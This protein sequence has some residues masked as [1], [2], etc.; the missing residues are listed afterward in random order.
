MKSWPVIK[1]TNW[2]ILILVTGAALTTLATLIYVTA[3]ERNAQ[4]TGQESVPASAASIEPQGIAALG[5]IEPQGEIIQISAPSFQEGGV[6]LE[7]LLVKLG[8]RVRA[9]QAIAILDN[10][11]RL[12]A[13][14]EQ[15]RARES[16]ALAHLEQVR[17]GAKAGDILA[18]DA[19]A[20]KTGAELEGQTSG[21]KATIATLEARLSGEKL[22]Q[23]ATIQRLQA[24]LQNARLD[25]QRYQSLY[26]AGA[27]AIRERDRLCLEQQTS[28]ARLTEAEAKLAMTINTQNAQIQ[29]AKANL[30]RTIQ[31]LQKQIV[32]DRYRL[33][34]VAEVR[35]VDVQVARAE[36]ESARADRK[37]AQADLDVAY[38]RAPQEGQILKIHTWPG[39]LVTGAGI[40]DLGRTERMYVTA[41]VYETDIDRVR[42]G[43]SAI[44]KSDG[45]VG[46]LQ[47]TVEEIGLQISRKNVLGTDPVADTDARVVEV[48]IRIQ[49][50]DSQRVAKLTNL[51]VNVILQPTR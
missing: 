35:P 32:E 9:G 7:R 30:T 3:S 6:R 50:Q 4:K 23:T 18:Q 36:L 24:E 25:C 41:E 14:L 10:Y 34:S 28:Q 42:V 51:R 8:D 43:Q 39:E 17:A 15:A 20:Q 46:E 31:T 11:Q 44:V 12:Q 19:H 13:S 48:K 38:A 2:P 37:K 47:G 40:A 5:Y 16:I 26:E 21:Q 22:S 27:V 33:K 49:P 29:E 1:S 45:I